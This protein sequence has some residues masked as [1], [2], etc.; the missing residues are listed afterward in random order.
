LETDHRIPSFGVDE[1]GEVSIV[2]HDGTVQ[3]IVAG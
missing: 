1:A 3:R 2:T